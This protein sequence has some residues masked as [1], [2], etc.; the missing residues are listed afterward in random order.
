[1]VKSWR[2]VHLSSHFGSWKFT[3]LPLGGVHRV[4][5]PQRQRGLKHRNPHVGK[6]DGS[7][8][9]DKYNSCD[10]FNKLISLEEIRTFGNHRCVHWWQHTQRQTWRH[11]C[12]NFKFPANY[13]TE[14]TSCSTPSVL[15]C[16]PRES[17]LWST[18][19]ELQPPREGYQK[20]RFVDC[21]TLKINFRFSLHG[22]IWSWTAAGPIAKSFFGFSCRLI[23]RYSG[24][25]QSME[26]F[27]FKFSIFV[28]VAQ[29]HPLRRVRFLSPLKQLHNITKLKFCFSQ[30]ILFFANAEPYNVNVQE[31]I[32][33]KA[34]L[35]GA[36]LEHFISSHKDQPT[37]KPSRR[38][39]SLGSIGNFLV[40]GS[41]RAMPRVLL[42]ETHPTVWVVTPGIHTDWK[43]F[44]LP[45]SFA[46]N[47]GFVPFWQMGGG[48]PGL[49]GSLSCVFPCGGNDRIFLVKQNVR[50]CCS[51][52]LMDMKIITECIPWP[53]K[54]I[55][56]I[57]RFDLLILLSTL[58]NSNNFQMSSLT[59][60]NVL[61]CN[62]NFKL[63]VLY[64]QQLHKSESC[65]SSVTDAATSERRVNV[66]TIAILATCSAACAQ[67]K[68]GCVSG[69][70]LFSDG[71]N[72]QHFSACVNVTPFWT[73]SFRA[74]PTSGVVGLFFDQD[75]LFKLVCKWLHMKITGVKTNI[76]MQEMQKDIQV[77]ICKLFS[78]NLRKKM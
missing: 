62:M 67:Q 22:N 53:Q 58:R 55:W 20:Q 65:W 7:W 13:S 45:G 14:I 69:S 75:L 64:L 49:N 78:S 50:K 26:E 42:Q 47:K 30:H 12:K 34:S 24:S 52:H 48:N 32:T 2:T 23:R 46:C 73:C 60:S 63:N 44:G 25:V 5:H 76:L 41:I 72:M 15:L 35:N 57:S 4:Q 33:Q 3:L 11:A 10:L 77:M 36:L 17:E 29:S 18:D 40:T 31:I 59:V 56:K 38:R 28:L 74:L 21:S 66:R 27:V 61:H 71:S 16:K 39:E 43:F 1:M 51:T 8:K 19:R 54:D 70:P 37:P 68:L 9:H 6:C